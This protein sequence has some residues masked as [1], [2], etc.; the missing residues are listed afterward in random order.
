MQQVSVKTC[1]KC[2]V[3]QPITEFYRHARMSDGHLNK[4]K[5]CARRDV[6]ENYR[7]R[8]SYYQEYERQRFQREE[9]KAQAKAS[10]RR[11]R[12]RHPEKERARLK[13]RRAIARGILQRQPC[14]VCGDTQVQAHHVDYSQP[15][16][17]QWLCFKHHRQQHGQIME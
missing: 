15:L 4:C 5:T 17:V 3:E 7:A 12:Q 8:R 11:R 9:R 6:A 13:T 2:Q 16:Q 14:E 10:R 1:F